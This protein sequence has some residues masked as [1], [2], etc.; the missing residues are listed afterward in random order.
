MD[1]VI[2]VN[3]KKFV[4]TFRRVARKNARVRFVRLP[5]IFEIRRN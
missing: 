4:P 5:A 3:A 1:Y 2:H